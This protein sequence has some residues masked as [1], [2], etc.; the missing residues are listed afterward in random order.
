ML[1]VRVVEVSV[2]EPDVPLAQT[3]LSHPSYL[4]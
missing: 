1:L 4:K 2:L 3:L